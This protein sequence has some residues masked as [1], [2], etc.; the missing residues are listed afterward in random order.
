M[1][2]NEIETKKNQTNQRI[3][4]PAPRLRLWSSNIWPLRGFLRHRTGLGGGKTHETF[5][6]KCWPRTMGRCCQ[7]RWQ[8]NHGGTL[9]YPK[10]LVQR[11]VMSRVFSQH[12]V[13]LTDTFYPPEENDE[14]VKILWICPKLL[15]VNH[16]TSSG[17]SCSA[18]SNNQKTQD[19]QNFGRNDW[20]HP[21][22]LPTSVCDKETSWRWHCDPKS[23]NLVKLG[24][25]QTGRVILTGIFR[26]GDAPASS[27]I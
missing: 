24:W 5:T 18:R 12:Q 1:N 21:W 7:S 17:F 6:K 3:L 23:M 25:E 15:Q 16:I 10:D 2:G 20:C 19:W 14:N 26:V 22:K 13:G 27:S 8:T 11:P 9:R 4:K